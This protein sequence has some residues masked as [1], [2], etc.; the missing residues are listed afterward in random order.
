METIKLKLPCSIEITN[1]SEFDFVVDTMIQ[2]GYKKYGMCWE[3]QSMLGAI[4]IKKLGDNRIQ[5]LCNAKN[6]DNVAYSYSQ[7]LNSQFIK[8]KKM[9]KYKV[10]KEFDH[11]KINQIFELPNNVSTEIQWLDNNEFMVNTTIKDLISKGFIE[12]YTLIKY[13]AGDYIVG[14]FGNYEEVRK[15]AECR[16]DQFNQLNWT[17]EE[18]NGKISDSFSHAWSLDEIRHASAEQIQAWNELQQKYKDKIIINSYEVEFNKD[19]TID[20]GCK[21]N[22]HK[23]Y[24][25]SM[26]MISDF[27]VKYNVSLHFNDKSE[28]QVNESEVNEYDSIQRVVNKLK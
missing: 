13:K 15:I 9:K 8:L 22:I 1:K 24:L 2:N 19:N 6:M 5:T 20:V 26:L 12:K 28:I 4:H 16:I 21:K 7:F 11:K 27:C 18:I 14:S 10:L 25:K 17:Q 23:G 3:Y